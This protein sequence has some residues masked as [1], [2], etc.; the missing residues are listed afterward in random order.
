MSFRVYGSLDRAYYAIFGNTTMSVQ[1][2]SYVMKKIFQ[3]WSWHR[4]QRVEKKVELPAV[5]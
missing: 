3:R 2:A 1:A 5:S 4:L